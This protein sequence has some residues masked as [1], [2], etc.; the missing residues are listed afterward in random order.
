MAWTDYLWLVRVI[1]EVLKVIADMSESEKA[2]I[3]QLKSDLGEA[4]V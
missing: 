4:L 1:I 2:K 3:A